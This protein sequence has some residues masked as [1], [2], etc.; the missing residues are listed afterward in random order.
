MHVLLVEP[1]RSLGEIYV[2]ALERAGH[3]VHLVRSAQTAI[4]VADVQRPDIVVV[5]LELAGHSGTAFLYEFR[6]YSDWLRVPIIVHT[7]LPPPRIAPYREALAE[8]GVVEVLYKPQTS[9]QKLVQV[10][11]SYKTPVAS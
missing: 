7:V 11:G 1:D 10:V 8:L 5:E 9:L 3:S 6:S 4:T 2:Q